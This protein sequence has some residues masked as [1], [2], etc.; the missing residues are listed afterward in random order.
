MLLLARH[1]RLEG[2]R[3]RRQAHAR[4]TST[5][6]KGWQAWVTVADSGH[7]TND[8]GCQLAAGVWMDTGDL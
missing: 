8:S 7:N 3:L 1:Q 6:G 2:V 4:A 5:R